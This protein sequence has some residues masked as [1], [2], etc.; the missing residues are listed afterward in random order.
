MNSLCPVLAV[1]AFLSA[2][3]VDA[4]GVINIY[5][6]RHYDTDR[7]LFARFEAQTGIHVN[8]TK[9]K[10]DELI[11]RLEIEGE[12]SPADLLI[13]V[14]A[15]RLWRAKDKGLLQPLAVPEFDRLVPA[16]LRD[17][18]HY[19]IG[20][21][22]RACVIAYAKDRVKAG[23]LSTYRDL[24]SRRWAGRLLVRSSRNIYNQSLLASIIARDGAESAHEWAAGVLANM[25]RQPKGNDRDQIKAIAAGIGDVAIINSYYLGLMLNSSNPVER[26]VARQVSIFFPDQDGH[27]SHVNISGAGLTR[28]SKNRRNA[29]RLL[30][31]LLSTPIQERF[32]EANYEYPVNPEATWSPLLR[33]WGE[34]KADSLNLSQLGAHNRAAVMIFDRVG[35]R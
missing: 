13:T 6:H 21:T 3:A 31:F 30:E 25:A 16:H 2:I 18:E 33:S 35:W 29:V 4:E 8:V 5:S 34:F 19:W 20:L 1:L 28:S 17:P 7:E 22:T 26:E 15:G 12:R 27:G 10:A 23:E 9:A 32:A 11:K 14:D 24:T